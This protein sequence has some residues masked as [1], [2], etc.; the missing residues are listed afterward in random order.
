MLL[1]YYQNNQVNVRV[2]EFS[3]CFPKTEIT[4]NLS[5]TQK[6]VEQH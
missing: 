3:V 4:G 6:D 5:K 2:T 1:M